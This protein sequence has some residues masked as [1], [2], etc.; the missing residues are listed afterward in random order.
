MD[1]SKA[2]NVTATV[3]KRLS[4]GLLRVSSGYD[5]LSALNF[6]DLKMQGESYE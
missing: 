5:F 3:I 6:E 2:L 1:M 4:S